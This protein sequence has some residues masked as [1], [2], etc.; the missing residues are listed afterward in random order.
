MEQAPPS[1]E[2]VFPAGNLFRKVV[3]HL[4]LLY[5]EIVVQCYVS[6]E[7][8]GGISL[9][10]TDQNQSSVLH[11]YLGVCAME[12]F[13]CSE[14]VSR[15]F[16]AQ[17]LSKMFRAVGQDDGFFL[18]T[19]DDTSLSFHFRLHGMITASFQQRAITDV[20]EA[21]VAVADEDSMQ[22]ATSV[23]MPAS[24]L[25]SA[26]RGLGVL[27]D[28]WGDIVRIEVQPGG[29][30]LTFVSDASQGEVVLS[31]EDGREEVTILCGEPIKLA[32][33]MGFLT[34]FTKAAPAEAT[35]TLSLSSGKPLRLS[36]EFPNSDVGF[37]RFF[38]CPVQ[39]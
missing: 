6:T 30:R 8:A 19:E 28:D 21:P 22:F 16:S 9:R 29:M 31:P 37:I 3:D 14:F 27:G 15:R 25:Q 2:A 24:R 34:R 4:R 5:K 11:A 17:V 10:A 36:F 13:A 1:L 32:F 7:G 39:E 12:R 20:A 33:S 35:A 18:E 23:S 26:F 38:L